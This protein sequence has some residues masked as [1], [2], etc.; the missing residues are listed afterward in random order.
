MDDQSK[1]SEEVLA[2]W[3]REACAG[4]DVAYRQF[5]QAISPILRGI[6]RAKAS[7]LAIETQEDILQETLLAIHHK[8]ATWRPDHKVKPWVY[9]IARYKIIDV[10]RKNGRVQT[11]DIAEFEE[12]L[13]AEDAQEGVD[14][15]VRA[16]VARLPK[17]QQ[18]V[19]RLISMDGLSIKECAEKMK[20]SQGA[21]RVNFHRGLERLRH[22][23]DE[24][25][26]A[27]G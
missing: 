17:K 1:A 18:D 20:M 6:I 5:L 11:L 14:L 26:D 10:F 9:A 16:L 12:V 21:V 8:R 25:N 23:H 3:L 13:P 4:D 22:Y 19:V 24:E 15:D 27:N 2:A 7:G